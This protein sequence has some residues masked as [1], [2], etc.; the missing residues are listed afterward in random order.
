MKGSTIK[1]LEQGVEGMCVGEKRK[2]AV[3]PSL[4]FGSK[5]NAGVPGAANLLFDVE[6]KFIRSDTFGA[7]KRQ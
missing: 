4:G 2:I 6:L 1:G 3:P 7:P 5:G